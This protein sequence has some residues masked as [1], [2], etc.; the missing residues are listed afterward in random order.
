MSC[1]VTGLDPVFRRWTF[2]PPALRRPFTSISDSMILTEDFKGGLVL[3]FRWR[4]SIGAYTWFNF[5]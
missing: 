3:A 4:L 2:Q 1:P 5:L